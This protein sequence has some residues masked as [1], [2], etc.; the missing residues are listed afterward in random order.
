[1]YVPPH[2]RNKAPESTT[3]NLRRNNNYRYKYRRNDPSPVEDTTKPLTIDNDDNNFPSLGGASSATKSWS[4]RKFTE[5]ATEWKA[6]EDQKKAE[7]ELEKKG[8]TYEFALPKFNN[9]HHFHEPE[10]QEEEQEEEKQEESEWVEVKKKVRVK[11]SVLDYTEKDFEKDDKNDD[12]CWGDN[13]EEYE[14]CWD[15]RRH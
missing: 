7:K 3:Q 6:E 2:L 12:T 15:E 13:R 14:T 11:K 4:G 5:L 8:E 10:D 1:M 9:I